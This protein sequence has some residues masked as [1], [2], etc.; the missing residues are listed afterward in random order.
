MKPLYLVSGI[1]FFGVVASALI[2]GFQ[3]DPIGTITGERRYVEIADAA[4]FVNSEPFKLAD[5]VGEKVILVDFMTYSCI[6]CQRTFPHLVSWYE[7]YKDDGFI[8]VGI[9]TPEFA[10]EKNEENVERA[11]REAGITY[12]IVLDNDYGTWRAYGNHYWPRKYLI[13]IHGNIVYDHI[14]EGAYEETEEKIR[15]LLHERAEVLGENVSFGSSLASAAITPTQNA[16]R[17]PETYFGSLRNEYF[18]SG[19]P[20]VAGTQSFERP[21]S[22]RVNSLYLPGTWTIMPEYAEGAAGSSVIYRYYAKDV[23]LVATADTEVRVRILQDGAPVTTA[24]GEDV[25]AEGW[26]TVRE[27]R[28]YRLV[29]NPAAGEHILEIQVPEGGLRAFAFTFG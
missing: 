25:D 11:M 13:D 7:S 16:A 29:S 10:F 15:E 27:D 24:R 5:F 17:S 2:I 4:G 12:P 1:I 23:Y 6:N 3:D 22:P 26:L 19:M 9:H 20:G 14:G 21:E 28:L 18:R 8:I